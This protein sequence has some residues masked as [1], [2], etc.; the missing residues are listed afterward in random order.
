MASSVDSSVDS[1]LFPVCGGCEERFNPTSPFGCQKSLPFMPHGKH[2]PK[3][4]QPD[5]LAYCTYC[6]FLYDP[7]LNTHDVVCPFNPYGGR[8]L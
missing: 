1:S 7:L 2:Q 6:N 4:E 5:D 3:W 8:H